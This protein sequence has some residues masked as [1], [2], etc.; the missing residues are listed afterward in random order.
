MAKS[1]VIVICGP[2]ASRENCT[3]NRAGKKN[4]W[5]NNISRFNANI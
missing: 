5:R 4:R 3:F 1:K 2:T